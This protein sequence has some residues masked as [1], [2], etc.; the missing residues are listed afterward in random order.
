MFT[1]RTLLKDILHKIVRYNMVYYRP[2]RNITF[3]TEKIQLVFYIVAKLVETKLGEVKVLCKSFLHHEHV[4]GIKERLKTKITAVHIKTS[5]RIN[6]FNDT[7]K[8]NPESRKCI[9][10]LRGVLSVFFRLSLILFADFLKNKYHKLNKSQTSHLKFWYTEHSQ[11][12]L[13]LS[14]Y[15]CLL[16]LLLSFCHLLY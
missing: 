14:N 8:I 5:Q 1:A 15:F 16:Q 9:Y 11:Y 12:C 4:N 7:F 10:L 2:D 6:A 3:R 13:F